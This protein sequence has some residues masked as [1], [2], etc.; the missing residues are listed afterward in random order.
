M[1]QWKENG[2]IKLLI[3]CGTLSLFAWLYL[4]LFHGR[5]WQLSR[6]QRCESAR[7]S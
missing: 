3:I 1:F 4:L 6:L 7:N 5:F 2:K